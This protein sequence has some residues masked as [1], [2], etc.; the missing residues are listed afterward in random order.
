MGSGLSLRSKLKSAFNSLLNTQETNQP[1]TS[2]DKPM[3]VYRISTFPKP[4]G[5]KFRYYAQL[6]CKKSDEKFLDRAHFRG[7]PFPKRWRPVKLYFDEPLWPRADFYYF[8]L[9]KFVCTEQA[10]ALSGH[11]LEKSGEFLPVT[12]EGEKGVYYIF[13]VTNCGPFMDPIRSIWEYDFEEPDPNLRMLVAPAFRPNKIAKETVFKI[14][15]DSGNTIY[16]V[17]RP[18]PLKSEF[19][20]LVEYHKLTGLKFELAWNLKRGS[21]PEDTPPAKDDGIVW[22]TG[23]GKKYRGK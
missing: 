8:S 7:S 18:G 17:E 22:K 3:N 23:D 10:R 13:N 6:S 15:E 19:K 14:P 4:L 9:G 11:A 1:G 5:T 12:I 20:R 16:C 21:V 2:S